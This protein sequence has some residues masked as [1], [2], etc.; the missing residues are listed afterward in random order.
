MWHAMTLNETYHIQG[1]IKTFT[2]EVNSNTTILRLLKNKKEGNIKLDEYVIWTWVH[3][4]S[5][6]DTMFILFKFIV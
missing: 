5:A 3:Y 6:Y 4:S 1:S 2:L